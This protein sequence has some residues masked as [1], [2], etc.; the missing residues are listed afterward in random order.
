MYSNVILCLDI[1]IILKGHENNSSYSYIGLILKLIPVNIDLTS[2]FMFSTNIFA[3]SAF[4]LPI[5]LLFVPR[6]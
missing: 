5:F 4:I 3:S 1:E 6:L 2:F